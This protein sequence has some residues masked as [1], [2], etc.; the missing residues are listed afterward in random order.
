MRRC[1]A[2]AQFLSEQSGI[3]G[4]L[5]VLDCYNEDPLIF[6]A[7]VTRSSTFCL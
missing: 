6:R 3:H 1:A 7:V 4:V 5:D 2:Q